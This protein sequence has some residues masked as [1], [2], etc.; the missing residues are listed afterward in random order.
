MK[1]YGSWIVDLEFCQRANLSIPMAFIVMTFSSELNVS[2]L[3]CLFGTIQSLHY[4]VICLSYA[5]DTNYPL[6]LTTYGVDLNIYLNN[7]Y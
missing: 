5:K 2:G 4:Y 1:L 7:N 3:Y 6:S